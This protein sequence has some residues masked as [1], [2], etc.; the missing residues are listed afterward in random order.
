M[1]SPSGLIHRG[2]A[3]SKQKM[4]VTPERSEAIPRIS[5]TGHSLPGFE[6]VAEMVVGPFGKTFRVSMRRTFQVAFIE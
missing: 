5:G 1:K 3:F 4:C 2:P 6:F